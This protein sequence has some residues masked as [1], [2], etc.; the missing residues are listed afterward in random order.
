MTG[1]GKIENGKR[2]TNVMLVEFFYC[3]LWIA[4]LKFRRGAMPPINPK[5]ENMIEMKSWICHKS[6]FKEPFKKK[7]GYRYMVNIPSSCSYL[8][9]CNGVQ[10][11]CTLI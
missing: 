9:E 5:E 8:Q 1:K 10:N 2:I 4:K 7:N 3:S 11:L 6:F